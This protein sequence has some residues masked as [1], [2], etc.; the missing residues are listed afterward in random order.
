MIRSGH[1]LEILLNHGNLRYRMLRYNVTL[2]QLGLA[3]RGSRY[4][5]GVKQEPRLPWS[6]RTIK[7]LLQ[8]QGSKVQGLRASAAHPFPLS[9][10]AHTRLSE[11][12]LRTGSV[13]DSSGTPAAEEEHRQLPVRL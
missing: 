9:S 3:R 4:E 5:V 6:A 11:S 12:C 10:K 8:K 1:K 2:S 13:C 7:N